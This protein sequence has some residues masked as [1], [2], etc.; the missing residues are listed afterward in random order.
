MTTKQKITIGIIAGILFGIGYNIFLI[1]IGI[2]NTALFGGSV[3]S[4][5]GVLIGYYLFQRKGSKKS[6]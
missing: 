5:M 4:L 6:D 3:P 1:K 2:G